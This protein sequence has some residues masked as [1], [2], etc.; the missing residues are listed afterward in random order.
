[1]TWSD[2]RKMENRMANELS[3]MEIPN[4]HL[5]DL[6]GAQPESPSLRGEL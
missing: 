1:M 6:R 4:A 5:V 3:V 2:L